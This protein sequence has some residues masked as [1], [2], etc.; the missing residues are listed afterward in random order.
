MHHQVALDVFTSHTTQ[1]SLEKQDLNIMWRLWLTGQF[2]TWLRRYNMIGSLYNM[3]VAQQWFQIQISLLSQKVLKS[4]I[5]SK[6]LTAAC[7]LSN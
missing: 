5:C 3:I 6:S 4:I 7:L 2:Q 1:R